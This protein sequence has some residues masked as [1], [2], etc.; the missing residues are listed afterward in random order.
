MM[1]YAFAKK[2]TLYWLFGM[3]L[4]TIWGCNRLEIKRVTKLITKEVNVVSAVAL[5]ATGEVLDIGDP[6]SNHGHCWATSPA[7]TLADSNSAL[8]ALTTRGVF[9]TAI[10]NLEPDT[11]Y[12]VRAYVQTPDSV[13]YGEAI[14][15]TT[16]ETT[17]PPITLGVSNIGSS[18]AEAGG[19][20]KT[21]GKSTITQHGHCWSTSPIPTIGDSRS[22]QG[23]VVN[24]GAFSSPLSG[25][26]AG[27]LYYVRSYAQSIG[28][29]T[30]GNQ[31]TFRT[32]K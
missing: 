29:I 7:P 10:S 3:L 27:T 5:N 13:I 18:E 9:T 20:I 14:R 11:R 26:Q 31:T 30:Y 19:F 32:A 1:F 21:I 28:G 2:Y 16:P 25:L 24:T 6:L 12:Y 17:P 15:V 4:S 23:V 22:N 8:G